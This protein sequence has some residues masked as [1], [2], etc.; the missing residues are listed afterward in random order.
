LVPRTVR[1]VLVFVA[2]LLA[3]PVGLVLALYPV[4]W[5]RNMTHADTFFSNLGLPYSEILASRRYASLFGTYGFDCTYA[6]VSLPDGADPGPPPP[7]FG[8]EWSTTPVSRRDRERRIDPVESCQDRLPPQVVTRLVAAFDGA[9]SYYS[10]GE[11][12]YVYSKPQSLAAHI[13]YGD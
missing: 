13:R 7:W 9:G 4:F 6:I 8:R 11:D 10:V 1:R 3:I 12:W 5:F 2:T